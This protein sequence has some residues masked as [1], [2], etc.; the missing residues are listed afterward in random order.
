[1]TRVLY[2]TM[3]PNRAST[4]V[5]TEGWMRLLPSRGLAPVLVSRTEKGFQDWVRTQGI[6]TYQNP[7]PFPEA[8]N[9]LPFLRSLYG[10]CRVVKKHDIQ[11][12]HCNE[13]DVYPVGQYAGRLCGVPVVV[14]VHFTLLRGFCEWA[15]G[16]KRQP[17]RIFFISR[18]NLEACRP[19]VEGVID[20][21]RWR[22]M[23]NGLDLERF[24]PD[25]AKRQAFRREHGL[26]GT[27]AIGV[28]CALRPRKQLEHLFEA[29]AR[30]DAPDLR[31][32]VA[33]GPV[34]GDE[35][36]AEA[37]L[38]DARAKLGSRLILLGHQD[39]LRGLYNGLDVFVNT[40]QEEA[41]SIS[42]MESL[43]CGCPVLGYPS[44]SVD[45]QILPEGGEI[46]AQ[47]DIAALAASLR[48]WIADRDLL[49]RRRAP[50]RQRAEKMF[51]IRKTS[52]QLWSEYQ[53]L[54]AGS[55]T[56]GSK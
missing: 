17:D 41:C 53:S 34:P 49:A 3:N 46:V 22:L 11:V 4:T 48:T 37:L 45:D 52:E 21:S 29:A 35:A 15:F 30:V 9:P 43:A 26:D 2:L 12:I 50:A 51:D 54:V 40:S 33:G 18:G 24:V 27:I 56:N 14:S 5:P 1:M 25:D 31:V 39:E 36:Y 8:K 6:P 42:V 28:A 13:Q 47:D 55:A 7:M 19:S 23:Y 10:I 20:E 44:K 32:V 38:C 16:G